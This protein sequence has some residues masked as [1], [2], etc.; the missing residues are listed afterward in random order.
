MSNAV[1]T[2]EQ[3]QKFVEVAFAKY[4]IDQNGTLEYQEVVPLAL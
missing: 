2:I 3:I 1:L 4:D